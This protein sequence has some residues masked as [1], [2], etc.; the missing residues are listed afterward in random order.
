MDAARRF[1]RRA[2]ISLSSDHARLAAG[3]GKRCTHTREL[4]LR[5]RV[6]GG[7][8]DHATADST[9]MGVSI[10]GRVTRALES[11]FVAYRRGD[12]S[13]LL[14]GPAV[15]LVAPRVGL[16]RHLRALPVASPVYI[17]GKCAVPWVSGKRE[18]L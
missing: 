9:I 3:E 14:F 1:P 6:P 8:S 15:D 4:G 11:P 18:L 12:R 5:R 16:A 17:P 13:N 2:F 10:Q 7:G